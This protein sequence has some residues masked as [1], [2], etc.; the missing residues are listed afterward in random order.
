MKRRIV[1]VIE[2]HFDQ[3]WRRCF[4]RDLVYKGQ[5]FVS[6]EKIEGY[7]I[8]ENLRLVKELPDYKFQIESPCVAENYLSR[9]PEREQ[10]LLA[11][12][13]KGTVKTANTGYVI[14]DSN[15]LSPEATIRN[16]L[17]ADAFF[18]K[19]MGYTPA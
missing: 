10:E 6:Y 13:Q 18:A 2:N 4:R 7:Y 17:I 14:L 9:F 5:N 19:F 3:I 15:M 12:Y 1:A 8:D 16:Y 11:L